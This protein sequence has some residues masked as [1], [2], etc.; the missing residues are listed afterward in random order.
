MKSGNGDAASRLETFAVGMGM[1][2]EET[3]KYRPTLEV[4]KLGCGRR[5]FEKRRVVADG[6]Y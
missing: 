4:D 1:G 2:V 3:R 5:V 6:C